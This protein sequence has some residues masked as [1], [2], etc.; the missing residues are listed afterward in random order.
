MHPFRGAFINGVFVLSV[1][2]IIDSL[3]DIHCLQ[4]T[5]PQDS[6]L[7]LAILEDRQLHALLEVSPLALSYTYMLRIDLNSSLVL[8]LNHSN[9]T[10]CYYKTDK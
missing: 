8:R 9:L 3:D 10:Y 5:Q 2:A 6:D 4:D 1:S 7:I